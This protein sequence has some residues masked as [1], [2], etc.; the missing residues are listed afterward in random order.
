LRSSN[1]FRENGSGTHW[2]LTCVIAGLLV[3][4]FSASVSAIDPARTVS[5]YLHDVWG[6][7]RGWPGGSITAIAQT[8]N[9][10][11]WIGT[12]K[13]LVRFDGVT[14]RSFE[15]ADPDPMA[16]GPVRSLLVD[17]S[18]NLW[19]LLQNTIVL[20]YR[21]EKFELVRGWSEN[22]T[23]AIAPGLSGSV[24][25]SSLAEGTVSYSDNQFHTLSAGTLLTDADVARATTDE[26]SDPKASNFSWFDRLAAPTSLVI[27]IAQTADGRI[28]L[29][30]EGRGL[31]YLR[32]GRVSTAGLANTKI[33]CLLP[34]QN[35]ALWVGT[36]KG[37]L[38]W[39]GHELTSA[40]IP[41]SLRNLDILSILRDRDSNLWIGTRRGLLRFNPNGVSWSST[42]APVSTLFEDREGNI[43]IGGARGLERLRDTGFVSHTVPQLDLQSLG[44][45]HVDSGGRVWVAPIHGGLRWMKEGK[46]GVVTTDG[47]ASDVVYSIAGTDKDD[48]WVGRQQ[49]GLTHLRSDGNIFTAKTYTQADGLAQDRVYTV[50]RGRDGSVWSGTLNRG[51]SKLKDGHFTNYS[52]TEG[53]ASNTISSIA[54]SP[55]GTMWF[56]TTNGVSALSQKGWTTYTSRDGLPS[57]DV[58]CLLLDSAKILWIGTAEGL[59]Y[60]NDGRIYLP[61]GAPASLKAPIFGMEEDKNGNLWIATSDHVLR[62]SRDNLLSNVVRSD[63]IRAF[64]QADGLESTQGV[65]RSRSVVSDPT[66]RIWFALGNGLSVVDPSR[67]AMISAPAITQIEGLS[68]DGGPI[69]IQG[70]IQIPASPRRITFAYTGLSLATPER[71]RFKYFLEGFD[72]GW[73]EPVATREAVY[74]NLGAGSYRFRVVA[75]NAD[76]LW[77]GSETTLAF[78]IEPLFW[79]TAWFWITCVVLILVS[80]WSIH[81]YRLY[82]VTTQFNLRLEERVGERTRIA[83]ELHDTLLQSF[84]GLLL[85]FQA[86]TNLL[87]KRPEEAKQGF[88]SAIDQAARAITES[89]DAVQ[90][91]RSS[92]VARNDLAL[93]IS[94]L[95]EELASSETNQNAAKLEVEVEGDPRNLHPNLRDEV[96]RI[97]GEALRN[98]FRHSQAKHIEV[99]IRF[100]EARLR[101]RVRDDGMGMDGKYLKGDDRP[102]HYGLR[103]M[104]ERAKLLGGKLAVWSE[105]DSGTEVE[106]LIPA[107]RAYEKSTGTRS[108]WFARMWTRKDSETKS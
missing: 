21:N 8:A 15:R 7:E 38:R 105:F 103:G 29:G 5:Q 70:K 62:V 96:Y 37:V 101:V 74:T 18:D 72:R 6:T 50:Y 11:L 91:L 24:L 83:R 56:G 35:S 43:W 68:V 36:S 53:L 77:N 98:A 69:S 78:K 75:S 25:L 28:W 47:I 1:T 73:S 51:V 12:D 30:T 14:F 92:S 44:S 27:S 65:K 55:D 49:G 42:A 60:L 102:G 79:Q 106:L 20:R 71:V 89:R 48:I 39:D 17:A 54:E 86:A 85:R 13:G 90:G 31:F 100:D 80:A 16:I 108:S 88:E 33:N 67:V 64:D 9:G 46:T 40:D 52:A 66:G 87:P 2:L 22:G 104:R 26:A 93:A 3:L 84:Q 45:L 41:S 59:A 23:T 82:L 76:N 63:G 95:G 61:N 58:N 10:Y 94:S 19:I 34:L 99:E 32:E 4:S 57:A 97:A 107:A 81:R